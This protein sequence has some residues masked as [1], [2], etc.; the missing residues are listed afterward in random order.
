VNRGLAQGRRDEGLRRLRV[1]IY[2]LWGWQLTGRLTRHLRR[3]GKRFYRWGRMAM[4]KLTTR[5]V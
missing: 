4:R 1:R 2:L 5:R 3:D